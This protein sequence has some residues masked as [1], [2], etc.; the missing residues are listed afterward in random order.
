MEKHVT[1]RGRRQIYTGLWWKN[2]QESDYSEDLGTDE[3]IVL[4]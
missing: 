2:V 3:R 4:K 1:G